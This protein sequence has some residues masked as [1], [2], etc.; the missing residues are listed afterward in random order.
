MLK[1]DCQCH[2]RLCTRL[3]SD[4]SHRNLPLHEGGRR[5]VVDGGEGGD[6]ADELVQQ[7][8]LQEVRLLRDGRLLSKNYILREEEGKRKTERSREVKKEKKG[9]KTWD[10]Y[11]EVEV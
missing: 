5:L 4:A 3:K 8:W 2:L 7:G 1:E 9:E 11:S 6:L 10:R